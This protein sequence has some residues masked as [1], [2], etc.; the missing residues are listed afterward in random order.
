MG[1]KSELSHQSEINKTEVSQR[2][3]VHFMLKVTRVGFCC[4]QLS[5]LTDPRRL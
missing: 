3:V 2:L 1:N 5:T 4:W